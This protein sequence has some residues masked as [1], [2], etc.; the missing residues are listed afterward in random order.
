MFGENDP[1]R[2]RAA[3]DELFTEDSVFHEPRGV[4]RG[5]AE[6]D[7]ASTHGSLRGYGYVARLLLE[8]VE[9]TGIEPVTS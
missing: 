4:Y 8:L 3:I 6:I 7:T 5:R 1:A 2:R 9:L